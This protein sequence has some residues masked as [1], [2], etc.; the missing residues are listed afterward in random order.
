MLYILLALLWPLALM[1][2]PAAEIRRLDDS[3]TGNASYPYFFRDTDSTL[4]CGWSLLGSDGTNRVVVRRV[5]L[6]GEPA[7]ACELIPA[8]VDSGVY[9]CIPI[10]SEVRGDSGTWARLVVHS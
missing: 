5:L 1:A 4:R 7:G 8:R 9:N 2:Q 6:S 10:V 3:L